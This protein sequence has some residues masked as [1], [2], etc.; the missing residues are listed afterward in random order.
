MA[1]SQDFTASQI[2][3]LDGYVAIVTGGMARLPLC[4][5]HGVSIPS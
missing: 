1:K 4:G 2:P 5:Y 3:R